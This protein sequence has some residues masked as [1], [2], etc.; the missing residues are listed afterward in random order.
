M[1]PFRSMTFPI[2]ISGYS[3]KDRADASSTQMKK[4]FT[5]VEDQFM[6][7]SLWSATERSVYRQTISINNDT[8]GWHRRLNFSAVVEVH[9][10][11]TR[12]GAITRQS[13]ND[14]GRYGVHVIIHVPLCWIGQSTSVGD[15]YPIIAIHKLRTRTLFEAF[16]VG[17]VVTKPF[18]FQYLAPV[19]H[20]DS[21]VITSAYVQAR[22]L[23]SY[24]Q[25][26]TRYGSTHV[27]IS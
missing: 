25:K 17:Q 24:V 1:F 8:E 6:E 7:S 26:R 5:Y 9:G 12:V 14:R 21:H 22:W 4:L 3:A 23:Q 2:R 16:L 27:L 20:T 18:G 15:L 10:Q 11:R 19:L 13:K